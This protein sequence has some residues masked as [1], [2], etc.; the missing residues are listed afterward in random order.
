MQHSASFSLLL[1]LLVLLP[2]GLH[3]KPRKFSSS[4]GK[5]L[6]AEIVEATDTNV[7]L[8]RASDAKDF[9]LPVDRLSEED[10]VWIKDWRVR[11]AP[12]P[13][14]LGWKRLRFHG[15]SPGLLFAHATIFG[16][17]MSYM[18]NDN[19]IYLPVG[20]WIKLEVF[21]FQHTM[22]CIIR[23]DGSPDWYVEDARG[24]FLIR[25]RQDGPQRV[26]AVEYQGSDDNSESIG[27]AK[28][29]TLK[30]CAAAVAAGAGVTTNS[31]VLGDLAKLNV[32]PE[33]LDLRVGSEGVLWGQIP[34]GVRALS[35]SGASGKIDFNGIEVLTRL[36]HLEIDTKE[37]TGMESL[38]K[39][40]KLE[41]LSVR[42]MAGSDQVA[43]LGKL[44]KLR[45]LAFLENSTG[46]FPENAIDCVG[47]LTRLESAFLG[48]HDANDKRVNPGKAFAN[49][50]N[51]TIYHLNQ[52]SITDNGAF[53]ERLPKL[54]EADF[55]GGMVPQERALKLMDSGHFKYVRLL[56][57]PASYPVRN[58]PNLQHLFT[59]IYPNGKNFDKFE[60]LPSLRE[61][62][63]N[64]T[65][66][67][68]LPILAAHT[69]FAKVGK[70]TLSHPRAEDL[71]GLREMPSLDHLVLFYSPAT[72]ADLSA[73]ASLEKV[74]VT[75]CS[76]LAELTLPD[77]LENLRVHT[78]GALDF[79]PASPLPHLRQL[80]FEHCES[81]K[82]IAPL[83]PCPELTR[84]SLL[85][86]K[87]L[88]TTAGLEK[89][90]KIQRCVIQGCGKIPDRQ[91]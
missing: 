48:S 19:E 13:Y 51:L 79:G 42:A 89:G 8:R 56:K 68:D 88:T 67:E 44:T 52:K 80:H 90:S 59:S 69:A 26:V 53:I 41:L 84:L 76:S 3:A 86:C 74:T 16:N 40:P 23:Y 75:A 4:N 32:S 81:L 72:R 9:T 37:I 29:L 31:S 20:A 34:P 10:R 49:C 87:Q 14:P 12:V 28:P 17:G 63:I 71:S 30:E 45:H 46:P 82:T 50:P 11:E 83:A 15:E 60:T 5:T 58:L 22:E 1:S 2:A 27:R 6:E 77:S 65:R 66:S 62:N 25:N 61:I 78:A 38:Q 47:E 18:E 73:L 36:E 24:K 35:I 43:H 33:S 39:L 85:D 91:K 21:R 7:T 70:L 64:G 54:T 55:A 57:T